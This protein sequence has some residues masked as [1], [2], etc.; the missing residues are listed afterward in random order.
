MGKWEESK[1]A[2][3]HKQFEKCIGSWE[4]VAKVWFGPDELADESE[5]KGK[6]ESVLGGRF[7]MY[8]YQGTFQAKAIEGIAIFGYSIPLDRF[9]SA[10]IDSFHN[11]SNIMFSQGQI[12]S[13][14]LFDAKGNYE[15][16]G[17][18]NQ[19]WGWR[20]EIEVIDDHHICITAYNISPE[21]EEVKAT[22]AMLQRTI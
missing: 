21:G 7:L 15:S 5:V 10:W 8:S 20:T 4:G 14:K 12:N 17:P 3:K 16:G 1:E 11:G 9:Q 19:I 2:G 6:I 22:E 13:D 18:E